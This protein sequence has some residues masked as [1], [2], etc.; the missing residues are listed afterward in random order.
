MGYFFRRTETQDK[1]IIE[2]KTKNWYI[3]VIVVFILLI[4]TAIFL[5]TTYFSNNPNLFRFFLVLFMITIF[6]I[7]DGRTILKLFKIN[8]ITREGSI[9]SP[10]KPVKYTIIKQK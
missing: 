1:T 2:L 5:A 9:F 3:F 8:N 7:L 4:P 6:A 10:K